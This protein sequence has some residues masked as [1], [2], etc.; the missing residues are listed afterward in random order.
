MKVKHVNRLI[1]P[2]RGSENGWLCCMYLM[3]NTY[4]LFYE[5]NVVHMCKLWL[6][7]SSKM[8]AFWTLTKYVIRPK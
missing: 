4:Y 1:K 8:F 5:L 6:V 7:N 2:V 3:S